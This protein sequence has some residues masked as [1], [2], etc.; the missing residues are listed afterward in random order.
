MKTTKMMMVM[1]MMFVMLTA[2]FAVAAI[3]IDNSN[4]FTGSQTLTSNP[5]ST[6]TVTGVEAY[7]GGGT[8]IGTGGTSIVDNSGNSRNDI[9]V[10]AA[11]GEGGKADASM[12]N[13]GNLNLNQTDKSRSLGALPQAYNHAIGL[14]LVPMVSYGESITGLPIDALM[15]DCEYFNGEIFN[16]MIASMEKA[17]LE[18]RDVQKRVK[19]YPYIKHS[20]GALSADVNVHFM[21]AETLVRLIKENRIAVRSIKDVGGFTYNTTYKVGDP[22]L[23]QYLNMFAYQDARA[24]GAN[25]VVYK[26]QFNQKSFESEAKELGG[27][28]SWSAITKYLLSGF[29]IALNAGVVSGQNTE[30]GRPGEAYYFVHI[31]GFVP[32]MCM[33][34]VVATYIA[35][36]QPTA[37]PVVEKKPEPVPQPTVCSQSKMEMFLKRIHE[38]TFSEEVGNKGI[39]FCEPFCYNNYIKRAERGHLRF[40]MYICTKDVKYLYGAIEDFEIAERNKIYGYDLHKHSDV[41]DII[42]GVEKD[43][44]AAIYQRDKSIYAFYNPVMKNIPGLDHLRK[45]RGMKWERQEVLKLRF[46][47]EN[48]ATEVSPSK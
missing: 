17:D 12:K 42:I 23:P 11:G 2:G 10:N 5:V 14:P 46:L 33:E 36:Q 15:A 9:K 13:S 6:A 43:L 30:T 32:S 4:G 41:E 21:R 1:A 16:T 25:V 48:Y 28:I 20:Y 47:V 35:P 19:G 31:D 18:W 44:S 27:G 22:M 38:L 26:H 8:G 3:E 7:A 40:E 45:K 24:N 37:P 29:G 39:E 34:K